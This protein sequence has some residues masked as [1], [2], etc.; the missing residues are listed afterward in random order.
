MHSKAS[1]YKLGLLTACGGLVVYCFV[2]NTLQQ[3][4]VARSSSVTQR[5]EAPDAVRAQAAAT[6]AAQRRFH[7]ARQSA[8][9]HAAPRAFVLPD[10]DSAGSTALLRARRR[11][12]AVYWAQAQA[13]TAF[14]SSVEASQL[15]PLNESNLWR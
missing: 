9:L 6:A 2:S 11:G 10:E 13:Q 1:V 3:P 5:R 14:A 4:S 7:A 8:S 15:R 12:D